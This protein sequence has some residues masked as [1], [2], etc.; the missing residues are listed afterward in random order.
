MEAQFFDKSQN[1]FRIRLLHQLL[2]Q[3]DQSTKL[4][5]LPRLSMAISINTASWHCRL[6]LPPPAPTAGSVNMLP[7]LYTSQDDIPHIAKSALILLQRTSPTQ[8]EAVTF[9]DLGSVMLPCLW[10]RTVTIARCSSFS[11]ASTIC[12]LHLEISVIPIQTH[13]P[14]LLYLYVKNYDPSDRNTPSH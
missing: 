6:G 9:G 4:T 14:T 1:Q 10:H 11:A 8:V 3:S 12:H 13:S 2:Q 7:L 5:L